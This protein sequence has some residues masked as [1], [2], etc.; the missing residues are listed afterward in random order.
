MF[1]HY[2]NVIEELRG[3]P[4]L[5]AEEQIRRAR[6]AVEERQSEELDRLVVDLYEHP[7]VSGIGGGDGEQ[8]IVRAAEFFYEPGHDVTS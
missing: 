3:E 1:A 8:E 6:Q 4:I 7:T 2:A 5:P